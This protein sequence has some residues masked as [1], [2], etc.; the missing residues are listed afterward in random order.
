MTKYQG[1]FKGEIKLEPV[2]FSKLYTKTVMKNNDSS[3]KILLPS[4]LVDKEV[5]VLLPV[6]DETS[7]KRK[8][9]NKK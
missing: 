1:N 7:K 6:E 4:N 2:K 9:R 3:G 8:R 5:V